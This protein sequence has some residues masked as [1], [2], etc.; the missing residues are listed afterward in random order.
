MEEE[1][2]E[3]QELPGG[4]PP[5]PQAAPMQDPMM[6]NPTAGLPGLPAGLS[7]DAMAGIAQQ[8]QFTG[9]QPLAGAAQA[10]ML[11]DPEGTIMQKAQD[12]GV[13]PNDGQ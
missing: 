6:A 1:Q 7:P 3:Q 12:L 8:L 5:Q 10:A 2:P 4:M 13:A 9:G 11:Q